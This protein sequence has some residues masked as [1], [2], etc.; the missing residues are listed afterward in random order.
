LLLSGD[1]ENKKVSHPRTPTLCPQGKSNYVVLCSEQVL[2]HVRITSS[3]LTDQYPFELLILQDT[4]VPMQGCAV[5]N[6][7]DINFI[8]C[9]IH[10][11]TQGGGYGRQ[12]YASGWTRAFYVDLLGIEVVSGASWGVSRVDVDVGHRRRI[13]SVLLLL[14]RHA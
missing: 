3:C 1:G 9:R 11:K 2:P 8:E 6:K 5:A 4:I 14:R 7:S 13:V 10:N 12:I